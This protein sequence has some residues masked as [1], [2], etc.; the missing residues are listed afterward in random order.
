MSSALPCGK[1]LGDVDHHDVGE[2]VQQQQLRG[3][4]ADLSGAD[5]GHLGIAHA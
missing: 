4:G 5:D 1:P 3:S 2:A